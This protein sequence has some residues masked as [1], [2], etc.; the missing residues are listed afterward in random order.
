MPPIA[1]T[2]WT[3][4]QA[5]EILHCHREHTSRRVGEFLQTARGVLLLDPKRL[6]RTGRPDRAAQAALA[7]LR[8]GGMLAV[9]DPEGLL[10][11]LR[12]MADRGSNG[13]VR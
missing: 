6:T 13:E 2:P 1:E 5:S 11:V 10:R 12:E 3:T 4:D 8:T 7:F 9:A